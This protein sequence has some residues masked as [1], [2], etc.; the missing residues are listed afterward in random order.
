MPSLYNNDHFAL[1]GFSVGI[2]EEDV[3][4]KKMDEGD[5][6]YSFPSSGVHSNGYSLIN[7]LLDTHDYDLNELMKPTTIYVKDI[8]LLKQKYKHKIKGFSHITGGGIIDNI[9]RIINEGY[10][11]NISEQWDVPDVFQWIYNR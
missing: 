5:L 3:Y 2:I 4:P 1:A 8:H 7:K 10:S 6:I 11:M 9:P